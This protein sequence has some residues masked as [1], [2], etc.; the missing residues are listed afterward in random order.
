M[1]TKQTCFI[2]R[3][4]EKNLVQEGDK[5]KAGKLSKERLSVLLCCSATGKKLKPGGHWSCC[6]TTY[7]LNISLLRGAP[8]KKHG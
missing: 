7:T 4:P 1:Q 8:T 3:Y 6:R 5:C 2:D